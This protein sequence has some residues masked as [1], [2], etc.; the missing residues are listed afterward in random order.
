[1]EAIG[2]VANNRRCRR[3]ARR[4]EKESITPRIWFLLDL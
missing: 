3:K 4:K 2:A 1:M